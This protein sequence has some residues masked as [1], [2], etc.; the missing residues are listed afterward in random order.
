MNYLRALELFGSLNRSTNSFEERLYDV[1]PDPN[2]ELRA[3]IHATEIFE[4]GSE[5]HRYKD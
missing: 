2:R 1:I 3:E 4:N 5:I